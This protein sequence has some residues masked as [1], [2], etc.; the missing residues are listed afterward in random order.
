M[1]EEP[2]ATTV[3][4]SRLR[5]RLTGAWQW[6]AFVLLT[7]VDAVVLARLPFS[8]GRG[9]LVGSLIAAGF[10]NI[11]VVAVV[12]HV[13]GPLLR[14]RR[15]HLPREV[16][17]DQAGTAGLVVLAA[18]LLAGGIA[19]RPALRANDDDA[20][21]AVSAA[22]RFAGHRAPKAYLPL[23]GMD[24]VQQGR[25]LFRSCFSGPD[26]RRDFCVFVRTDE[27]APIVRPDPD[28]RPNATISGPDNPGRSGA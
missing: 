26:P 17:G 9:S 3:W 25:S 19:H 8:G 15:R 7:L 24:T 4:R 10:L 1:S 16:A 22:A 27:P 18:L 14:R 6:P 2:P 21:R 11:I 13:G 23:H 12:P 28:Q 5:W 20:R